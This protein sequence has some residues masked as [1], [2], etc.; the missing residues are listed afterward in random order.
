MNKKPIS[1]DRKFQDAA[2]GYGFE[3]IEQHGDGIY[4]HGCFVVHKRPTKM[5]SNGQSSI[6]CKHAVVQFYWE[7]ELSDVD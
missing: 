6:M 1:E 4:C 7:P 5:Y 2:N 3:E